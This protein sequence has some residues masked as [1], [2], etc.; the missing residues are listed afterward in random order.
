MGG[1]W[2]YTPLP[3]DALDG[4]SVPQTSPI[5]GHDKPIWRE[6]AD[7]PP[8]ATV[9]S[10]LYDGLETN[11]PHPLM[12][13]SDL[14]WTDDC[15]LF[16]QH[17]RVQAYLEEYA[18]D[19][20]HLI[21]FE[22]QVVT[23]QPTFDEKWTVKTRKLTPEG[24]GSEQVQTF[25]AVV[26]ASGH[27]NVPF[28]PDVPGIAEWKEAY[29][30]SI[31]HSKFYRSPRHYAGQ[32]VIVVG[33]AASGID[34]GAQIR[35]VCRW[36]LIMSQK[37][38]SYLLTE[39]PEGN[40]DR[41]PIAEYIAKDRSVRFQDGSVERDI[42]AVLYCTGYLYSYPFLTEL[43]PPLITTGKRVENLWQHIFYRPRPTLAFPGLNMK[44]IPFPTAEV[45]GAVI[46]GVFAGRLALPSDEDMKTWEDGVLRE[47]GDG[48]EFHVLKFPKDAEQ[49]N[50]LHSW[51]VSSGPVGKTPPLWEEKQYWMRE[52]FPQ[53]KKAFQDLGEER[54][55]VRSLE[56]V[57]F[58]YEKWKREEGQA[59]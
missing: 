30:G 43:D 6:T 40:Q 13:F 2:K 53:I 38:P 46:A 33:N 48:G 1:L 20:Q 24:E 15:Q 5:A 10:P 44:V 52:R 17:G 28:I 16:P 4:L 19:V 37:S 41:P 47:Q 35:R 21:E 56:G 27:Y 25:D 50:K 45:Q 12:G 18:K 31:S 26:A 49:I 42:D 9:L 14:D 29:P 3:D 32:K 22:T 23:V 57:G 34:I 59:A 58:D 7:G 8:E 36:P 55:H 51:A 11:I 54:H 39:T